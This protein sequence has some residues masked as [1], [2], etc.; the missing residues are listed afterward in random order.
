MLVS[1]QRREPP[2]GPNRLLPRLRGLRRRRLGWD[3]IHHPDRGLQLRLPAVGA[4]GARCGG[5]SG[6]R[7][8]ILRAFVL[9]VA[10]RWMEGTPLT[11]EEHLEI[12]NVWSP[13]PEAPTNAPKVWLDLR[14]TIPV[15]SLAPK[16]MDWAPG[17]LCRAK[18]TRTIWSARL[19]PFERRRGACWSTATASARPT[20]SMSGS[21]SRLKIGCG[22][23]TATA[24][25]LT[26]DDAP[27]IADAMIHRTANTNRPRPKPS[28][29]TST[30]RKPPF[31]R[32]EPDASLGGAGSLGALFTWWAARFMAGYALKRKERRV[33]SFAQGRLGSHWR[34]SFAM[35]TS[36]RRTT[37]R[38]I[39]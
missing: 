21:G 29:A 16:D 35:T 39:C 33:L 27:V 24:A 32:I 22:S 6:H 20:A 11:A 38:A 4:A 1:T 25:T 12:R 23:R 30:R 36:K 17:S 2:L 37:L 8:A 14:E 10:Y 3:E 28:P 18:T 13:E 34:P 15:L 9:Y 19:Q 7:G 5:R 26:P 31:R